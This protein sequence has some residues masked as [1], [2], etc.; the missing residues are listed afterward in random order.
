MCLM[1]TIFG[2]EDEFRLIQDLKN[3]YDPIE[4]P[5]R[6]HSEPIRV[7]LRILLQ[8]LVDVVSRCIPAFLSFLDG[9]FVVIN[10]NCFYVVHFDFMK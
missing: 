3:N 10:I 9:R 6:N 8:Q 5:V 1:E 4:R 2:S 7:N